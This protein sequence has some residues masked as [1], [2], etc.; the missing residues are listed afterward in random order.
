MHVTF[1]QSL[2]GSKPLC[3]PPGP[4]ITLY[5]VLIS[6]VSSAGI[7]TQPF[8]LS[9]KQ[10]CSLPKMC[11]PCKCLRKQEYGCTL[12]PVVS[13]FL[14]WLPK[15]QQHFWQL[16]LKPHPHM[17]QS[18][19]ETWCQQTQCQKE[20]SFSYYVSRA[21]LLP[22]FLCVLISLLGVVNFKGTYLQFCCCS[23]LVWNFPLRNQIKLVPFSCGW[24]VP[25]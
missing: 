5:I 24:A 23:S 16:I 12:S 15:Q 2:M 10:Y 22:K 25:P 1:I 7:T 11:K 9:D 3:V 8:W 4:L 21:S 17:M 14:L 20:S 18:Q 13:H 6:V 19:W